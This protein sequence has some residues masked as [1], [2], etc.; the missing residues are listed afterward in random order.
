MSKSQAQLL[1]GVEDLLNAPEAFLGRE[2]DVEGFVAVIGCAHRTE[3]LCWMLSAPWLDASCGR[4]EAVVDRSYAI[5][6]RL[7]ELSAAFIEA[8]GLCGGWPIDA[9]AEVVRARG[10]VAEGTNGFACDL[11]R[12]EAVF[13]NGKDLL[14]EDPELSQN[15]A[16]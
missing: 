11:V 12:L 7:P 8:V 4:S 16:T 9:Y 5:R 2:V 10:T 13:V 1:L 15:P 14:R 3:D 6:L